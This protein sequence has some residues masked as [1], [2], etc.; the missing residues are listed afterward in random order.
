MRRAE[1]ALGKNIQHG[2][3]AI[4]VPIVDNV[5][6]RTGVEVIV[7]SALREKLSSLSSVQ[8][9]SG[10]NEAEFLLL[11]KLTEWTTLPGQDLVVGTG[12]TEKSGGLRASQTTAA[13]LRVNL[14]LEVTL[15]HKENGR[16]KEVWKRSYSSA[17]EY[18]TSRR[19]SFA[20]GATSIPFIDDS[21]ETIQLKF[22]ADDLAQQVFD[23]VVMDF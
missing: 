13:E 10:E 6:N 19:F 20:A 7:T 15:L 4:F 18:A 11:G 9:V 22:M 23:Q 8:V 21:R 3:L 1:P 16:V 2:N 12:E 17:Q 14:S 5:T